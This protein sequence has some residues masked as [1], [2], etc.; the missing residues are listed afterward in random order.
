MKLRAEETEQENLMDYLA[1]HSDYPESIRFD[2]VIVTDASFSRNLGLRLSGFAG[3]IIIK[4]TID[5]PAEEPLDGFSV[6]YTAGCCESARN[7]MEAEIHAIVQAA[8]ET[9]Q[10]LEHHMKSKPDRLPRIL[11]L[12]DL[13]NV[14]DPVL[15]HSRRADTTSQLTPTRRRLAKQLAKI[16]PDCDYSI[17]YVNREFC[18]A[19]SIVD[20]YSKDMKLAQWVSVMRNKP[21]LALAKENRSKLRKNL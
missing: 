1:L 21:R 10:L 12:T 19:L 11:F 2:V 14:C 20:K 17:R 5:I 15:T 13:M 3:L 6:F 16:L 9:A 18:E 8:S 7:S 4:D